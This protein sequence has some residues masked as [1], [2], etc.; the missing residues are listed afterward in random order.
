MAMYNMPMMLF[1]GYK[2]EGFTQIQIANTTCFMHVLISL[3][4]LKIDDICN[5]IDICTGMLPNVI[6]R[7]KN[8]QMISKLMLMC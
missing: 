8:I 2:W 4:V 3:F 7:T 6:T 5:V 1:S